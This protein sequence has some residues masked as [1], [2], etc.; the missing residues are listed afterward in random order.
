MFLG[1]PNVAS[2]I[3]HS[4]AIPITHVPSGAS[5]LKLVSVFLSNE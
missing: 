2:L 4:S 5:T 3:R 1:P